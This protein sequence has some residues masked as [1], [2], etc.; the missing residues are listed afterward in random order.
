MIRPTCLFLMMLLTIDVQARTLNDEN[1]ARKVADQFMTQL[2][3]GEVES[4]YNLLSAYV[5]VDFDQFNA[6]GKKIANDLKQIEASTGKPIAFALLS[7]QTV[8][9]HFLKLTYLLKFAS[10]AIVWELNF[11]Q[12]EAG[13]N[14]VDVSYHTD[15]NKLF[16]LVEKP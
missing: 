9:T 6:R 4:G 16:R 10:A 7:T 14:L 2:T 3:S 1:A 13:W 5:G 15:I 12:P 8:P 11:Y